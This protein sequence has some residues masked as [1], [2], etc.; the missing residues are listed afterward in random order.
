MGFSAPVAGQSVNT[1]VNSSASTATAT[2]GVNPTVGN[3]VAVGGFFFDGV[4]NI[5]T[6]IAIQDQNGNVYTAGPNSPAFVQAAN[7]GTVFWAYLIAPANAHK[8]ITVTFS[9]AVHTFTNASLSAQEYP[10][11]GGTA[12]LDA[13]L[14]GS[15]TTTT[16][17][18]NTPTIPVNGANELI[19]SVASTD[20]AVT[21][22]ADSWVL[23]ANQPA[24]DGDAMAYQLSVSVGTAVAFTLVDFG[25]HF[26]DS[27]GMSFTITAAASTDIAFAFTAPLRARS[28]QHIGY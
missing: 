18:I 10:V 22:A 13:D 27:G 7:A 23:P 12:S 8:A 11:S 2:L 5:P 19:V 26:W 16:K 24:A 25:T 3:V 21:S 1:T 17:A 14:G 15:G 6:T 28:D 20:D 9:G 4:T